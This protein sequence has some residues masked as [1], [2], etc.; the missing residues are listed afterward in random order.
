M[1]NNSNQKE[2]KG[3]DCIMRKFSFSELLN[4][5]CARHGQGILADEIGMD[6]AALLHPAQK[7]GRNHI[8]EKNRGAAVIFRNIPGG[9]R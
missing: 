8:P 1:R 4:E 3:I 2:L 6:P 5:L 9:N 7:R